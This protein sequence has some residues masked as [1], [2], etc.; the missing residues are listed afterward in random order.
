MSEAIV[1]KEKE[2]ARLMVMSLVDRGEVRIAEAAQMLGVS[3]RQVWR[4]RAAYRREGAAGL[5]HGNRGQASE[6]RV[7]EDTRTQV[8]K[9]ARSKHYLGCNQVHLTELL[10]E[11]EGI[12]LSRSTVRR[13]LGEAGIQSPR[14][15]RAPKH[16]SRR[17]RAPARG[18]LVQL[19]GSPHDWL[20]DRGPRLC[21]LAAIDDASGEIEGATFR[22][23]EDAAGYLTVLKQVSEDHG[24]PVAAYHDGH[25]IFG[26]TKA[27]RIEDQLAGKRRIPSHVERALGELGVGSIRALSPQA[28]GRIERLFGT[29]QDRLVKELRFAGA[30]SIEEAN[31]LLPS[32]IEA[33]NRQFGVPPAT[34]STSYRRWPESLIADQVF[35]FK[36]ERVVG[37]DNTVRFDHHRIQIVADKRRVSYA[38]CRVAVH[39]GLD[40]KVEVF[41]QGRC[42]G[43]LDAPPEAQVLRGRAG[44]RLGNEPNS[45]GR[46]FDDRGDSAALAKT[47]IPITETTTQ[48]NSPKARWIP[49]PDHPW[50]KFKLNGH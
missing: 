19:D 26:S 22:H 39:E 47:Q 37:S 15:R 2:Q 45:G 29:L 21:L 23:Q 44:R 8:V 32:F 46:G 12:R 42:L 4:L 5:I 10:A 27:V 6:R 3:E 41:Y 1:L 20:E 33:F 7:A 18:M 48:P 35:C 28:K 36:Y 43:T 14:R 49:P 17:E 16:R 11:H 25:T 24:L 34:S 13:I 50:R 31:A 40:G 9:A 38:K 30:I